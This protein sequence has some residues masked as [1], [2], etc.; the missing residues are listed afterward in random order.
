MIGKI[1]ASLFSSHAELSL[2][3]PYRNAELSGSSGLPSRL[4]QKL[5]PGRFGN[6]ER[7]PFVAVSAS[8]IQS[9]GVK[10]GLTGEKRV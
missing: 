4:T 3:I 8:P 10:Q 1:D 7:F 2:V 5:N 6:W 9:R